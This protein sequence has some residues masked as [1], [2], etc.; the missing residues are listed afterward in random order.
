MM[1][2]RVIKNKNASESTNQVVL[3]EVTQPKIKAL[4]LADKIAND[5]FHYRNYMYD[6][7]SSKFPN[8]KN[9]QYVDRF[10]PYASGGPLAIDEANPMDDVNTLMLKKTVL[11]ESNIRYLCIAH[12]MTENEVMEQLVEVN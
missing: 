11:A 12:G 1:K 5:T 8:E 10:Y 7:G 2:T 9:M 3:R 6:G 4:T